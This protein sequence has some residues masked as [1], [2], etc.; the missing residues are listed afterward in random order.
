MTKV[1]QKHYDNCIEIYDEKGAVGVYD[2]ANKHGI[3]S[4]SYCGPCDAETPTIG[5]ICLVC[6][7]RKHDIN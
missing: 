1:E 3:H 7:S 4:W 6:G 5:N 2:Y